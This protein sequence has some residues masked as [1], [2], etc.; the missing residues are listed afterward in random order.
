MGHS[1]TCVVYRCH[2]PGTLKPPDELRRLARMNRQ[3][4]FCEEHGDYETMK[5]VATEW[6]LRSQDN[7]ATL[8]ETFGMGIFSLIVF[9][10]FVM[11]VG[12]FMSWAFGL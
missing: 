8:R 1:G 11:A 10:L 5:E 4:G 9:A 7:W 12:L 6:R 3:A 2:Q